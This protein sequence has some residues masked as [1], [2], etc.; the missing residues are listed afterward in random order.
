MA[1]TPTYE[2]LMLGDG[3]DRAVRMW[4]ERPAVIF[5]DWYWTCADFAFEV[6]RVA[7]GLMALGAQRGD[8]AAVWMTNL[9]EWLWLLT[10]E[11]QLQRS[12]V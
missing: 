12:R 11:V 2:W 6:D 10:C 1:A 8:H 7:K 9:S 3:V 4:G 5:G